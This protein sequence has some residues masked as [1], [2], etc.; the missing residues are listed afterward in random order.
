MKHQ[1]HVEMVKHKETQKKLHETTLKLK[2][3]EELFE[4]REKK[5]YTASQ[6]GISLRDKSLKLT[7]QSL[8][9]LNDASGI[10][11][12]LRYILKIFFF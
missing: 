6:I 11:S 3:L 4:Q 8:M 5:F 1:L 7:S 2:S 12:E 10:R 9:N